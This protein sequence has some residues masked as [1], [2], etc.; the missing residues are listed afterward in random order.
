PTT[1][2]RPLL[3]SAE[4][5]PEGLFINSKTGVIQGVA[6]EKKEATVRVMV[7][8][9]EGS[10]ERVV[11]V[12]TGGRLALT[13]PLGW[14]SWN[15]WGTSIDQQNIN[16]T[17]EAMVS[18]GLAAHGFNFVN[19][20]DGWQG[21]RNDPR[22]ALQPNEKFPDLAGLCEHVHALGLRIGI[23]STPWVT[24]Y[25]GYTGGSSGER[26][27]IDLEKDQDLGRWFGER[28]HHEEDARQWA[29]WGIDYLKY[30]WFPWEVPE[31]ELMRDA[32][33][34]CGRDIVYSL[35]NS[36]PYKNA[37]AWARL[38]NC[39][40]TTGDITDTWESMSHI[41]F[42]Q[43]RWIPYTGPGHF[44]DPD[45]LVVGRLGWGEV[46]DNRLTHDEQI[47]HITLWSLLSAPLLL[48]CDMT[49]LDDF[50][51]RLMSNDEVLGINQDSLGRQA[52]CVKEM[53]DPGNPASDAAVYAKELDDGSLA[54]GL[55][56]RADSPATVT[57][58][59]FELGIQGPRAARNLW[60]RADMDTIDE[61]LSMGIPAHGAQLVRL[62]KV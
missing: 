24:S 52:Y 17:A 18:S 61:A 44:S 36:A 47:T 39:W 9:D 14:N 20:D 3:F 16:D 32:L 30:D 1:G 29:D 8:N 34:R 10:D 51:V 55:F 48:G 45:M 23:Y 13:P 46:R 41:G 54:V 25:G 22:G 5:L 7:N 50:T 37:A 57:I 42:A 49:A 2:R 31:T 62:A 59:W 11:K 12:I 38:A 26:V 56:N 15:V 58:K 19:I 53:R 43:Q 40:R 6:K 4:G 27:R 60:A 35:S 21:E 28:S 33:L